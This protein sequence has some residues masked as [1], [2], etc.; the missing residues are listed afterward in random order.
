MSRLTGDQSYW[1]FLQ[2]VDEQ[3]VS[4]DGPAV[5]CHLGL[6]LGPDGTGNKRQFVKQDPLFFFFCNDT[7]KRGTQHFIGLCNV[8]GFWL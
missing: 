6:L 4:E 3:S 7:F 5:L 1:I 2:W 8:S